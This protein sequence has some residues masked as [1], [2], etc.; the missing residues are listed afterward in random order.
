MKISIIGSG[1]LAWFT[2]QRW[3][4]AGH[5]IIE[6]CSRNPTN[7][8]AL[9]AA[10]KAKACKHPESLSHEADAFL[11][12]LPDALLTTQ[13]NL[14]RFKDRI[15]IHGAGTQP[16]MGM[17]AGNSGVIWPLFSLNKSDLPKTNGIPVFWEAHGPA[18]EIAIPELAAALSGNCREADMGT[19]IQLHL[20]AVFVNNFVNHLMAVTQNRMAT[21][22]LPFNDSL[23]PIITQT[24]RAAII[25]KS[26]ESQTGPAIRHDMI[27][28]EKHLNLLAE[29]PEWQDIY[30][31][32]SRSI[33]IF[34][35]PKSP[36]EP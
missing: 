12:A 3:Q 20:S 7:A 27:T 18:A 6:I 16:A 26:A 15:I 14:F 13:V 33:Q 32:I 36:T 1:N 19:R 23:Q 25:G 9:A 4:K 24:L 5:Q 21:L 31:A 2:A 8:Q 29:H 28:M 10:V 35:T 34:N 22:G 11:F 17:P 30:Q